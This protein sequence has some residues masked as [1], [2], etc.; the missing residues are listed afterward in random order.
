MADIA[1]SSRRAQ[2]IRDMSTAAGEAIRQVSRMQARLSELM[3]PDFDASGMTPDEA[4]RV[5]QALQD[6]ARALPDVARVFGKLGRLLD[7]PPPRLAL[8][9]TDEPG[10]LEIIA[11]APDADLLVGHAVRTGSGKDEQW[12]LTLTDIG[13][14]RKRVGIGLHHPATYEEV[15]EAATRFM[16]EDGPWWAPEA[17]AGNG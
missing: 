11:R 2:V 16:D 12:R 9:A 10:R 1:A 7:G 3:T 8:R 6:A 14:G 15:L 13:G 5:D 4:V 17:E